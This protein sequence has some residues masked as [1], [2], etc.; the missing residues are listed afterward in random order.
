[1]GH[2]D[3][4]ILFSYLAAAVILVGLAVAS[5]QSKKQDENDLRKLEEQM[6][7]LSEK[8]VT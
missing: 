1:M 6:R 2:N 8:Q 7:E 3:I 5:W 4:Y